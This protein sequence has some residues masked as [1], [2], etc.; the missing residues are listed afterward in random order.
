MTMTKEHVKDIPP[1]AFWLTHP[2]PTQAA[3]HLALQW[4]AFVYPAS[5]LQIDRTLQQALPYADADLSSRWSQFLDE[6]DVNEHVDALNWIAKTLSAEQ[7]PFLVETCWRLLLVDHELPTHVPLA[8]RILGQILSI[9]EETILRLGE[10]VFREYLD[11]DENRNRA[12]LLPV[13]PRYLDRVEWRL[14]GHTATQRINVVKEGKRKSRS[15]AGYI[16]FMLG[17]VFGGLVVAGLVFG[18][19]QLGRV[20]VPIMLHDGLLLESNNGVP[21]IVNTEPETQQNNIT[22]APEPSVTVAATGN[23]SQPAVEAANAPA[24]AV[25]AA[26]NAT[27]NADEEPSATAVAQSVTETESERVLMEVSASILNVRR[28]PTVDSDVV[29]KL[30]TGAR[31]WAYPQQASGLWMMVKV[32]GETGYASARFLREVQ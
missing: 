24:N 12:P 6:E 1:T 11:E 7:I 21:T 5:E 22:E 15:P 10:T 25:S 23:D 32:E 16:G 20:T 27:P 31:V 30:A 19:L 9:P 3:V 13:D 26:D 28:S 2:D 4:L 18:P 17:T 29:I 14:Y 8:L